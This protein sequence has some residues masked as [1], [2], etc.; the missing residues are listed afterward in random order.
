MRWTNSLLRAVSVAA[1]LGSTATHA[2]AQD[3]SADQAEDEARQDVVVVRGIRG[4]LDEALS[5]KQNS[6]TIGDAISA[7]DIGTLPALDIAEALQVVPGVQVNREN[8]DGSFRFGEISLRGLPGSFTNTTANGQSFA[9]PSG[10]VTPADGVPNAFGAFSSRVFDGVWVNKTA[11][12]DLVEGG[13]A[14]TVDQ[15]LAKALSKPDGQL[16]VSVG[17]QY[18]E[19]PEDTVGNF[20]ATGTKH[21]IDD[22]LAVTFK[23]AHEE[24][25]FQRDAFNFTRYSPLNEDAT[26]Q[27]GGFFDPGGMSFDEWK[28]ANGIAVDET[29]LY[30]S[31]FRQY[32]EG[33]TG[34]RTSFVGGVEYQAT[35]ELKLG[36]DYLYSKRELDLAATWL[37]PVASGIQ[38]SITPTSDPFLGYNE[39]D[40]SNV[41]VVPGYDYADITYAQSTRFGDLTQEAQGIF[42]NAEYELDKWTFDGSIAVSEAEFARIN[43][44]Y[45]AQY[46]ANT[47]DGYANTNGT[48]GSINSGSGN[49]DNYL[50]TLNFDPALTTL[51]T[52]LDLDYVNPDDPASV[53]VQL[54]DTNGRQRFFSAGNEVFRDRTDNALNLNAEKEVDFGPIKSLKFGGRY[55]EQNVDSYILFNS[56][57]GLNTEG[58]SND[59]FVPGP[60][61]NFFGG[62]APGAY[63][64]SEWE[65]V[66]ISRT[67]DVLYGGG[68]DNPNGFE[69]SP[70]N[71]SIYR[72]SGNRLR[73]AENVASTDTTISAVYGLANFES[74]LGGFN[75]AGNF[76]VRYVETELEG[77][78]VSIINGL[79][80]QT[81]AEN[82]YSNTLPALN[83]SVELTPELYLRFGYSEG[84][85]RPNPAGFTPSLSINEIDGAAGGLGRVDVSLPGT[86]VEAYTSNNYDVSLEWYNRAGSVLSAAAYRKDVNSFIDTRL[87]C[88]TDGAGL[89]FGTLT[90]VDLGG[91]IL[92]CQID[93]DGREIRI[94]ETFNFDTTITIDGLEFSVQQNLDFLENPILA[95]FGVQASAAFV[96]VSGEDSAG[97][98]AV[99]PRISD[100]SYN[101]AGYWE[102]DTF[103]AR[104]AYNWR[105]EYF[106]AGGL[107]ITGIE[108]RIVKPRGQ[109]DFIGRYDYNDQLSFNF[110]AFNL[111]EVEYEEYQSQNERMNRQTAF[112]GRTFSIAATY[113]F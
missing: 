100:E 14:G 23:L 13:I 52:N 44:N 78:G 7:D 30:P 45:Q 71:G 32:S 82:S 113:K 91:G 29:V 66:D 55:N 19:L 110:R 87:V 59:L 63:L 9:S 94:S 104:L 48:F 4:A 46:L 6:D 24:E 22:K 8:N 92:E 35:P 88:P 33:R 64:G 2:I 40:G 90:E 84:I 83:V 47:A 58:V 106:L 77:D 102:N 49:S 11:R 108:D 21:L 39:E 17:V 69:T 62:G 76:G 57:A 80:V 67:F 107:S 43:Q 73:G 81:T 98:P 68:V 60:T 20:F 70:Y 105:S 12:A 53:F 42:L 74:E 3:E 34:T 109:L 28:Q 41:W 56:I 96:D 10:T 31:Q 50:Y 65:F 72:R 93:A 97:N 61:S 26:R 16:V 1:L 95:G 5:I 89:G 85:N 112:D 75:V 25:S 86:D 99:V 103:S 37:L 27:R 111:L 51:G 15:R 18:E 36:A 79:P 38:T 54:N 101:V